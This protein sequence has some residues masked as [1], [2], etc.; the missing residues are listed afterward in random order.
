MGLA[1]SVIG[2]VV[3]VSLCAPPSAASEIKRKTE[4]EKEEKGAGG[5]SRRKEQE[6]RAGA[7]G[8]SGRSSR[9][10]RNR[11][12]CCR[13]SRRGSSWEIKIKLPTELKILFQFLW[14]LEIKLRLLFPRCVCKI[15]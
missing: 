15:N 1:V 11:G 9:I 10:K 7:G 5:R 6:E 12:T 4:A 3:A 2:S 8:K 14:L 13:S